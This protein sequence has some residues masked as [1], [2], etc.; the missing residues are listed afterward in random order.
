MDKKLYRAKRIYPA[1]QPLYRPQGFLPFSVPRQT[2]VA[3]A[4]PRPGIRQIGIFYN[5]AVFLFFC[6]YFTFL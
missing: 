5:R 3:P 4:M 2:P 1:A 6:L